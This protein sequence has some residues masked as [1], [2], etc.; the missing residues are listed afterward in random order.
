LDTSEEDTLRQTKNCDE[1]F[2][3]FVVSGLRYANSY[4]FQ[5]AAVTTTLIQ[6]SVTK[7]LGP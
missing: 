5:I 1:K 3:S 6:A 4:C 7:L 2:F